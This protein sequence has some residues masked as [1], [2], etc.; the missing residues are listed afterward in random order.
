MPRAPDRSV[1]SM[2]EVR[3]PRTEEVGGCKHQCTTIDVAAGVAAEV[4]AELWNGGE[5]RRWSHRRTPKP[6]I[7][8]HLDAARPRMRVGRVQAWGAATSRC[9]GA[10]ATTTAATTAVALATSARIGCRRCTRRSRR[11]PWARRCCSPERRRLRRC[12]EES[13]GWRGRPGLDLHFLQSEVCPGLRKGRE[14]AMHLEDGHHVAKLTFQATEKREHHLPIADW[15]AE[16]GEGGGHRLEVAIVVGDV[17][18]TLAEVAK[19]C[20]EEECAGL[21]L[22]EEL[23][24]EIAPGAMSGELS[25]HQRLLQVVGDG[26]INPCQDDAV[27]LYPGRAIGEGLVLENV[28]S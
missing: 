15:V 25:Q 10:T 14:R 13:R 21:L 3:L 23:V 12:G 1:V 6:V 22:A 27:R 5:C 2:V 19:L 20:L 11:G 18:G 26:A 17:Q 8:P 4:A 24:L 9:R 28:A 16:L 7:W